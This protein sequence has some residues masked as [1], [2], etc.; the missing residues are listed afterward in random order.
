MKEIR[1]GLIGVFLLIFMAACTSPENTIYEVMEA[2]AKK[3]DGFEK[4]QEPLA[5]LEADEKAIFDEIM[6]LGM[7]EFDEITKLADEALAN[8]DEREELIKK[9]KQSIDESREEFKKATEEFNKIKDEKLK[10]EADH[11]QSLMNNRYE[12]HNT[13]YELYLQ[14]LEEDRKIYELIKK[15]DL[16][17][18]ELSA[19]IDTT[20]QVYESIIKENSQFNEQTEQFNE[21]KLQF[22][23]NAGI[24]IKTS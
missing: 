4:Q 24:Q 19:Q 23:K 11:L 20:N 7:K 15:D 22:Y 6:D 2:T 8:L 16:Q 13:L 3:E 14:G 18:E 12:T 9:E 10:E 21:A 17:M 5:K 1:F